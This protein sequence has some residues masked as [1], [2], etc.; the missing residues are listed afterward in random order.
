[1]AQRKMKLTQLPLPSISVF[2]A[3]AVVA[4]L[5]L[6]ALLEDQLI[7]P[8]QQEV[9]SLS[10]GVQ[11]RRARAVSGAPAQPK[12]ALRL[13]E[14]LS[15]LPKQNANA[16][17][18]GKLHQFAD[19]N[20]VVLRKV[21]YKNHA[22]QGDLARQ[23]I[24]AEVAGPYPGIRQFLRTVLTQDEAATLDLIEFGRPVGGSDVRAQVRVSL[25]FRRS[26]S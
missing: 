26:A 10:Q 16:L 1:M 5:G 11:Q 18:V 14:V 19:E 22:L 21:N 25:Y 24:Q 4:M 13:Q 20:G 17:R 3:L 8:L 7:G 15:H 9:T 2:A 23:E 12:A 6:Q